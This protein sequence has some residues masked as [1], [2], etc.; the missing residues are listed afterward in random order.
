MHS[1]RPRLALITFTLLLAS[2]TAQAQSGY[3]ETPLV[4]NTQGMAPVIDPNLQGAWGMSFSTTSALWVSDQADSFTPP[5]STAAGAASFY[6]VTD[7]PF[8]SASTVSAVGV[9]NLNGALPNSLQNNGPTGEV[10]TLAPGIT[11]NAGEFL[12]GSKSAAFIFA[13]LD[14]SISGWNGGKSATIET[15]VTGASFTGLAIGNTSSGATQ[16][17]AADQNN[18]NNGKVDIFNSSWKLTGTMTDPNFSKF[19]SGY[20]P[21]N[22]QNLTVNG[23]QTIFVTYANQA[24]GG[25]IVDEFTTNGV[26]IKTLVNDT[27]GVH[28]NAPWGIAIAPAGWGQFGGDILVGNNNEDANGLTEINAYNLQGVWEGTLTLNNGQPFSA[29]ELWA[30]GF[31][32]G[33][34]AGSTNTLLFTAGLDG[35]TGGFVGAIA[36]VPEPSSG[37]LGLIA[38]AMMAAGWRWKHRRHVATA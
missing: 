31:G 34:G 20:A 36:S 26:F 5:G 18:V 8:P 6:K 28:L 38:A 22:V 19:P 1:N 14:G 15:S 21:F 9:P 30:I 12:V 16:L 27:A 3:V 10:N 29:T 24:T 35:N 17:Y 2:S 7:T 37:I 32:N 4:S 13:N 11:M 25:G 23:V 33:A